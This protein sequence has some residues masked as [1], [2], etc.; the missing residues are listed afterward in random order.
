MTN[1]NVF[2]T[3]TMIRVLEYLDEAGNSAFGRWFLRL[4]PVA[5]AKIT[6]ALERM[7]RGLMGDVKAVG[8][9]V[10]E[11]RIDFGP[12]YR[13]YF[14]SLRDRGSVE[15][16]ILL[17]GGTK[18]SQQRDIRTA[19]ALWEDYKTRKRRGEL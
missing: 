19:R 12:G 7:E 4:N 17:C 11:R 3:I 16:V 5:A 13:L 8:G 18:K 10:S 1:G 14:G 15:V 6:T 9:G 2:V